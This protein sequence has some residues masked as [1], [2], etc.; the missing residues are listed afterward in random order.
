MSIGSCIL[1]NSKCFMSK[2]FYELKK[3]VQDIKLIYTDTDSLVL[4]FSQI[5]PYKYVKENQNFFDTSN[6]SLDNPFDIKQFNNKTLGCFK[7]E[8]ANNLITEFIAL[9]SKMY[10]FQFESIQNPKTLRELLYKLKKNHVPNFL[11]YLLK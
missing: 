8:C 10:S 3:N 5:D 4:L 7:D 6:Y 1:D 11:Y 9:Q 2:K